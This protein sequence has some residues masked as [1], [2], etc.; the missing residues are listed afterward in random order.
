VLGEGLNGYRIGAWSPDCRYLAIAE[1]DYRLTD[2]VV[3]DAEN[4]VRMGSVPDAAVKFHPLTWGPDGYLMVESRHGAVLW[5]VPSGRQLILTTSFNYTR[6][7]N[8]VQ[9]VWDTAHNQV[10][11]TLALGG[12]AAFDLGTGAEIPLTD[13]AQVLLNAGKV[14]V[15]SPRMIENSL[16]EA[17]IDFAESFTANSDNLTIGAVV[18]IVAK[19]TNR[20]ANALTGELTAVIAV[21]VYLEITRIRIDP[22]LD[23]TDITSVV[24]SVRTDGEMRTVTLHDPNR[25]LK[26]ERVVNEQHETVIQMTCVFTEGLPAVQGDSLR[27]DFDVVGQERGIF[28]V[29]FTA[30]L[31]SKVSDEESPTGEA[32]GSPS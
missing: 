28:T 25:A 15:M 30:H 18:P 20:S 2:T 12:R 6:V 9:I 8:F 22:A 16:F 29:D 24:D 21:P 26:V 3:Y 7:R 19:I 31:L 5:H 1:G 17:S 27:I 23:Y 4:G 14:D 10:L 13:E 32:I 11:V